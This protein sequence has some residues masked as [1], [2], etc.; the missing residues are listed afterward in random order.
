MSTSGAGW[1][2]AAQEAA[3][4]RK[5]DEEAALAWLLTLRRK[6]LRTLITELASRNHNVMSALI[7][8]R[9]V[10]IERQGQRQ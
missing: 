8:T 7:A 6:Q 9:N 5:L 10:T 2:R 3:A 1:C 4:E